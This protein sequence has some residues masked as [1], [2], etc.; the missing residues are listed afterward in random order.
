MAPVLRVPNRIIGYCQGPLPL[1]MVN[2][3][4]KPRSKVS[5]VP[6]GARL[7]NS[8]APKYLG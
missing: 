6:V 5:L 7:R 3:S 8:L 2:E 4:F 1:L